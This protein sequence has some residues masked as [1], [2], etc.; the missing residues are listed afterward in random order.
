MSKLEGYNRVAVINHEGCADAYYF[1]L[2]DENIKTGDTVLVSGS[3]RNNICKIA[4]V[5]SAEDAK[6][7]YTKNINQEVICVVDVRDY[8]KRQKD[9]IQKEKLRKEMD[10]RRAE[11]QKT[12]EDQFYADMDETY[13]IMFDAYKKLTV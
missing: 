8:E 7:Y 6:E 4:Q 3:G 13:A 5:I 11:L 10:K 9:R 2:Y 1:A 12:R